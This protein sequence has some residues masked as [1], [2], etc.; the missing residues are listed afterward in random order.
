MPHQPWPERVNDELARR[1][2]PARYRSRLLAELR[3]HFD[4]L[5]DE[6]E[7]M[8]EEQVESRLGAPT[9]L[10]DHAAEEYRRGRFTSRH[11]WLVFGLLPIPAMLLLSVVTV[12]VVA[13]AL[14]GLGEVLTPA[15]EEMP[16]P[17]VETAAYLMAG[18][19]RFIPFAI[20]AGLFTRAYVRSRVRRT[21]YVVAVAQVLLIAGSLVSIIHYNIEPGQSTWTIGLAWMP[22]DTGYGVT[23]PFMKYMSW[24]Q[25]IQMIVP[26]CIA[27]LMLRL[28][29]RRQM[30]LS[31]N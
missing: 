23:L 27:V 10:A 17:Y 31:T 25:V 13:L 3:D 6:G 28:A 24:M 12:T 9:E 21:W 16:R 29:Q 8:T 20:L 18:T 30:A 19:L 26:A 1:G 4:D 14:R 2:V 15:A 5:M 11:P 7:T 22:V